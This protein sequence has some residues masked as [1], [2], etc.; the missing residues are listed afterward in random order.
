MNNDQI[1]TPRTDE[2]WNGGLHNA[3]VTPQEMAYDLK[4]LARQL[5]R[6]L[7]EANDRCSSDWSELITKFNEARYL[8]EQWR[9]VAEKLTKSTRYDCCYGIQVSAT[10]SQG[11]KVGEALTAFNQL[12]EQEK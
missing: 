9:E 2:I 4:D 10:H 11:C 8:A 6:E 3:P 5:E 7:H 1:P 12:K